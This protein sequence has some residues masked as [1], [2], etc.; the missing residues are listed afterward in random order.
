MNCYFKYI[1]L[2]VASVFALS[3]CEEKEVEVYGDEAYL[4]FE[5]PGYG[6]NNTPRDSMVF[7]FPA[8]GDDCVE[9]TLWFKVRIIGKAFPYDREIKL[10]VNEETTT[11]KRDENYKLEPVIMPANS[12]TV[13]VP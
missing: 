5:M 1:M 12:Y 2:V 11:A 3:S 9:D 10:V 8:K 4:V 13:D 7:S 6:L